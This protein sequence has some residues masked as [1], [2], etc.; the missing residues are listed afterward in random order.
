MFSYSSDKVEKAYAAAKEVYAAYGVDTD[1]VMEEMKKI[2]VSIHCWQGDDVVGFENVSGTSGGGIM[3]T[4]NYPGRARNGDELR[5][6]MDKALSL[7]PG[8]SRVNL[9]AMY[10]E[11][12]GKKV[13]RDELTVEHFQRWIDWAKDKGIGIDFNPTFFAHPL[14][15]SGY[16]LSSPDEKGRK[17]WVEHGKRSR[18][19]AAAI[20]KALNSPC[21]NNI[22]IPDGSKDLPADRITKRRILKESLDEV[23]EQKFSRDY[24]VDAVESKLFGIGSES[25]V[26]GSHEFYMG[27]V[28]SRDDV[29]LCLDAGHFHPTETI[30]DKISSIL[31][32]KDELL[33][34]VS[35][36]VRWDSD[37]VVIFNDDTLSIAQEIKRCNAYDKVHFALDFFDASINRITAWV[38]GTRAAL[39]A[40]MYS[41]LEPT[42]LLVEAEESGNLG[43]RLALMEEFKSLP[44]G[45]VWNKY[46]ADNNVPV[47]TDWIN[48]VK[49]YEEVLSSRK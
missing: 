40:I 1:K 20:G 12:D 39:K 31:T 43:N 28:I 29:I 19:I 3:A 13:D 14:A 16:T 33:L 7:I 34:H 5:Q 4:G 45:A 24:L 47:G 18:E 10:A 8:K 23:L 42:H 36:G 35:R 9:H 38:T 11:T 32:Y 22:W 17:F 27:Y 48:E 26:V 46:C 6:D 15:D 41:L 30:A 37:H 49:K 2:P 25:Y 44:F 21:V